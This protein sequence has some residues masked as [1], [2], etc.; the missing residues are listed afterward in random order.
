MKG[1]EKRKL[2]RGGREQLPLLCEDH[3]AAVPCRRPLGLLSRSDRLQETGPAP[4]GVE[5]GA[6]H[7]P[8]LW[9]CPWASA[10]GPS[11]PVAASPFCGC[12][13]PPHRDL[14]PMRLL[15]SRQS[16][17][18]CGVLRISEP[19]WGSACQEPGSSRRMLSKAQMHS[20]R[21]HAVKPTL[22]ERGPGVSGPWCG[23]PG[24]KVAGGL[25]PP[26]L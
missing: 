8:A 23:D 15:H 17:P 10:G 20:E 12:F 14:L 18:P 1:P 26:S 6:T 24:R 19:S 25:G 4:A 9:P 3:G 22:P 13:L 7:Q 5:A 16:P 2:G 11:K 21:L